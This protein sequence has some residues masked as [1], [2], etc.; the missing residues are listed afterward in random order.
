MFLSTLYSVAVSTNTSLLKS[1]CQ[2]A[3]TRLKGTGDYFCWLFQRIKKGN[4]I[5]GLSKWIYQ[6]GCEVSWISRDLQPTPAQTRSVAWYGWAVNFLLFRQGPVSPVKVQ[7]L[8]CS[9]LQAP[10]LWWHKAPLSGT[11]HVVWVLFGTGAAC[12]G[13]LWNQNACWISF[14]GSFCFC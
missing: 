1:Y 14:R 9:V 2:C 5:S 6:A 12:Q 10:C 8:H 11:G 3:E 13:L 4:N 7:F